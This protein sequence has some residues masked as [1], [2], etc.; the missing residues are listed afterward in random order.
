MTRPDGLR[1]VPACAGFDRAARVL[2]WAYVGTVLGAGA[3]GVAGARVD[4]PVLLE[5]PL[6]GL[7]ARGSANVLSQYRF[8]RG[9]EAGFGLSAV[10]QREAI[11]A[12]RSLPN[13]L[14]LAAMG[15]GI[16]GRVLGWAIDGRPRRLM[17]GFLAVEV[18]GWG[19]IAMTTRTDPLNGGGDGP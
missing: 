13:R 9:L 18:A 12:G 5:Q 10:S 1:A 7:S 2:F 8:L 16:V 6:E 17:L 19:C 4:F 11:F 3:W 14:F 15:L